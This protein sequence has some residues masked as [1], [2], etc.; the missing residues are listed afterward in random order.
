[1]PN[2]H[3][4]GRAHRER[5]TAAM[6][7]PSSKETKFSD[8]RKR[9]TELNLPHAVAL[10]VVGWYLPLPPILTNR[11]HVDIDAPI[12]KWEHYP[13]FDSARECESTNLYVH[14]QAKKVPQN[15]RVK[16]TTLDEAIAEQY[17]NGECIEADDPRLKEK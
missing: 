10:A 13:G 2:G 5:I 7:A 17:M 15:K 4:L 3:E 11:L 8:S 6:H 16:P 12:S 9:Q 1:M 14:E